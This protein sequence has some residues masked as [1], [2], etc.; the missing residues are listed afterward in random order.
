MAA[1]NETDPTRSD[2]TGPTTST[3]PDG[4]RR[5]HWRMTRVLTLVLLAIW[6]GVGFVAPWFARDLSFTFFGWPFSFWVAA[7]G[8]ACVFVVL[9]VVY[10]RWMR[11]L[12]RA[13][14]AGRR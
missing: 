8:G 10:A 9:I 12:D 13:L 6:F 3:D 11:R 7:Q 2:A 1:V 5:R 14:A 4:A